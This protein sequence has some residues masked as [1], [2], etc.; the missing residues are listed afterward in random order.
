MQ[1]KIDTLK[2]LEKDYSE[3]LCQ[4][5]E[6]IA[7][8]MLDQQSFDKTQIYT[9]TDD[10]KREEGKYTVS[11]GSVVFEA[12]S[13]NTKYQ[14]NTQVYVTIPMGNFT[15]Q[16]NILGR[17]Q[18]EDAFEPI[19]YV[20]VS[21]KMVVRESAP[22][23]D[24]VSIKML[25]IA[26]NNGIRDEQGKYIQAVDGTVYS[27]NIISGNYNTL[28][29]SAD[30][31]T[32]LPSTTVSGSYGL[33]VILRGENKT[34]TNEETGES[35]IE[36][37]KLK[38]IL[39][40]S[41]SFFGNPYLYSGYVNMSQTFDI[42]D[43][44]SPI[45]Q[46]DFVL[47]EQGNFNDNMG[48]VIL[49]P[50][51]EEGKLLYNNIF[52][53][54]IKL[55]F[56]SDVSKWEDNS[57]EIFTNDS[58]GYMPS[59]EPEQ[60]RTIY[61]NFY[62][63]DK[64]NKYIGFE[65]ATKNYEVIVETCITEGTWLE[66]QRVLN[67]ET[68]FTVVPLFD[69]AK[70]MVRVRIHEYDTE[71]DNELL[72]TYTSNIL[73]F[74][75]TNP[76]VGSDA[77]LQEQE[78][79]VIVHGTNSQDHY[80]LYGGD[81]RLVGGGSG[82]RNLTI[83]FVAENRVYE[84]DAILTNASVYWYVPNTATMLKA[85][86]DDYQKLITS[87]SD[88][89]NDDDK[90]MIVTGYDCY[91][92]TGKF[93]K[94][95]YPVFKYSLQNVYVEGLKNNTIKCK[96]VNS[97][98]TFVAEKSFTFA[99]S[100]TFGTDHTIDLRLAEGQYGFDYNASCVLKYSYYKKD[101][102]EIKIGESGENGQ[103]RFKIFDLAKKKIEQLIWDSDNGESDQGSEYDNFEWDHTVQTITFSKQWNEDGEQHL[104]Y[105]QMEFEPINSSLKLETDCVIP[106][107]GK[108]DSVTTYIQAPD[109]IIYDAVGQKP[110]YAKDIPIDLFNRNYGNSKQ[111]EPKLLAFDRTSKEP[112]ITS[113]NSFN[114][115]SITLKDNGY[116]LSVPE[117]YWL[118]GGGRLN[119]NDVNYAITFDDCIIWPLNIFL[120]KYG[121]ST[122]NQ[123]DSS[124]TINEEK[125]YLL[126]SMVGA[127][128]KDP[129]N[130]T[131]SGVV[132]GDLA[133]ADGISSSKFGLYGFGGGL[134]TFA[135]ENDG[136]CSLGDK[137]QLK[138]QKENGQWG[139]SLTPDN[140]KILTG[141]Y[142][143]LNNKFL[144]LSNEA[145]KLDKAFGSSNNAVLWKLCIGNSFGVTEDG[146]LHATGAVIQGDL[147]VGSSS[148]K[149]EIN[150]NP[151]IKKDENDIILTDE[152]EPY[153]RIGEYLQLNSAGAF[154]LSLPTIS[155]GINESYTFTGGANAADPG[156]K[157]LQ[158]GK[159]Y[160]NFNNKTIE[161]MSTDAKQEISG[162]TKTETLT[163]YW[164]YP[165]YG[166]AEKIGLWSAPSGGTKIYS[167][168]DVLN[169]DGY[170]WSP[171]QGKINN[172]RYALY[173]YVDNSNKPNF[174]TK[175][176]K[177]N[178]NNPTL[179]DNVK[180][181]DIKIGY[182]TGQYGD[183][184]TNPNGEQ[185]SYTWTISSE[186]TLTIGSKLHISDNDQGYLFF[187]YTDSNNR[188][189]G[190]LL[191]NSKQY[192]LQIGAFKVHWN[193]YVEYKD[194]GKYIE[195]E[196]ITEN[197]TN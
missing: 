187:G 139:L 170:F 14:K 140:F 25:Q 121:Y 57:V 115:L 39:L 105:A 91:K 193:G 83:D 53:R 130:N 122:L 31:K 182:V 186:S 78:G 52:V 125:N 15:K 2:K 48:N 42:S 60:V 98:S 81:T 171:S 176:P 185:M 65:D 89:F 71:K 123:W 157:F 64:N 76:N 144:Y 118:S 11:D 181:E 35:I 142:G 32:L 21:E 46:I 44:L 183:W 137:G 95:N 67:G 141:Q 145:I 107:Y 143:D 192:A 109:T 6:I 90:A 120:N 150:P 164:L 106:C 79:L 197:E 66:S 151:I 132:M 80:M 61:I 17:V 169:D 23:E 111:A 18:V 166:G 92:L 149:I 114:N 158:D 55:N 9:I 96:I 40:D 36:K 155:I 77:T 10:S 26:A 88:Q 99:T 113:A 135:L 7:Q 175:D 136:S 63:K 172:G 168:V 189:F 153:F 74:E 56:G 3:I 127:G 72:G 103:L 34:I 12:Y 24:Q 156:F 84:P 180:Y 38:T 37:E 58:L 174:I 68:S 108:S 69:K 70:Y 178:N 62:N 29:I 173:Y 13:E 43:V 75:N 28:N 30:F 162:T 73:T 195:N 112:T 45:K 165:A 138:L 161:I 154:D 19:T 159:S 163:G 128:R 179:P 16:K 41:S 20:P 85:S 116:Y 188:N 110:I 117:S 184:L 102:G 1:D 8:Q 133:V 148:Q 147:K 194:P 196:E 160:F 100:G 33:M 119:E 124:F 59:A 22:N 101:I 27:C 94:N 4:A 129:S 87:D 51:D 126:T 47:Y 49:V 86:S 97:K 93:D 131:F 167:S 177:N 104:Y 5:M 134:R 190:L 152:S 146:I 191:G 82:K 54:N 50:K